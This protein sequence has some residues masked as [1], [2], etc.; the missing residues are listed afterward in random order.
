VTELTRH[1]VAEDT[2][3]LLATVGVGAVLLP[4]IV[5]SSEE[6][7]VLGERALEGGDSRLLVLDAWDSSAVA[8]TLPWPAGLGDDDTLATTGISDAL[9]LVEDE[10]A[11]LLGGATT[12]EE[13]VAVGSGVVGGLAN[14]WVGNHCNESVD[15]HDVSSVSSSLEETTSG[16]DSSDNLV[17]WSTLVDKLVANGDGV[18]GRPVVLSSL[19]NELDLV[20][21]ISDVENTGEDL[22]VLGL[23][24]RQ[25][26]AGLVAVGAVSTEEAVTVELGEVCVHIGGVLA[27]T[28][29]VVWRVDH[30]QARDVRRWVRLGGSGR[31]RRAVSRRS[32]AALGWSRVCGSSRAVLGWGRVG[33]RDRAL[34]LSGCRCLIGGWCSAGGSASRDRVAV[35]VNVD[36]DL[37][38]G[39]GGVLVGGH[40]IAL[41]VQ[42]A[43]GA[44]DLS[45]GGRSERR[46][47]EKTSL[48]VDGMV[49]VR[50]YDQRCSSRDRV[51]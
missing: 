13:S 27:G 42:V 1:L 51:K 32:R 43:V 19:S 49:D 31:L 48:H 24:G 7:E 2:V 26:V 36:D 14:G 38:G 16:T 46:N 34:A 44:V 23:S 37:R 18:D 4:H 33:G 10:L 5:E 15:S 22:G 28:V 17:S 12:V 30:T 3:V 39:D 25:N 8:A 6:D 29:V 45:S 11:G 40:D 20:L 47:G 21:N 9:G 35:A 41:L 50:L